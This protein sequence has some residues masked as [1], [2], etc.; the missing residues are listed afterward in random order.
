MYIISEKYDYICTR[1]VIQTLKLQKPIL[2]HRLFFCLEK[3]PIN[4]VVMCLVLTSGKL[5]AHFNH[6]FNLT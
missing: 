2:E 4:P 3:D 5:T 1:T 6:F